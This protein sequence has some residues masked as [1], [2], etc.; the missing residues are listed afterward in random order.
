[1][2]DRYDTSQLLENQYEPGS[3]GTVLR[4]LAG[5]VDPR[6]MGIA[7]TAELWRL[8]EALI[9][10]ITDDQSFSAKEV[11]IFH[12]RWLQ[13]LYPWAGSGLCADD[14]VVRGDYQEVATCFSGVIPAFDRGTKR[15]VALSRET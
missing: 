14:R 4:N 10:E 5:I 9:G 12:K 2:A 6:E 3:N 1:M 7:E 8:Q 15:P 11:C 13:S